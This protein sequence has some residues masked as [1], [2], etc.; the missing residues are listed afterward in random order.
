[1]LLRQ[2]NDVV[3]W[4]FIERAIRFGARRDRAMPP[5][6]AVGMCESRGK[7]LQLAES[8]GR[9]FCRRCSCILA[10]AFALG[11]P[12][13]G[14]DSVFAAEGREKLAVQ[15]SFGHRGTERKTLT[16][17][18]IAG[19]PGVEVTAVPREITIG[20]G[21]VEVVKVEVACDKSA[22]SA[23][24]PHS[25]WK[26]LLENSVSNQV[27]RL[28]HDPAFRPGVPLLTVLTAPDGTAGFTIGL[29]QLKLHKA[30]WLPEHDAFVTLADSQIGF[31]A[32]LASLKG[33]RILDRV[34]RQPESTLAEWTNKWEDIGN[35]VQYDKP[36]ESTWLG[37]KG[38]L[39]GLTARYG[40]VYKFGIDR[41]ANVRPDLGSPHKFRFDL[42][43]RESKWSGQRIVDGLPI[44]STTFKRNGQS[45][46][47]E[48]FAAPLS[49][50]PANRRG[51]VASVLM[52]VMHVSGAGPI[53]LGFRL[54]TENTNCQPELRQISGQNC[55]VDRA[56]GGLWLMIH[57]GQALAIANIRV[58]Q[59]DTNPTIEF[60]C[61][62]ELST[63]QTNTL[64]VKLPS[65]VA[66]TEAAS[67]LA[68]LDYAKARQATIRYWESWLARGARFEVPE[69]HVNDL[70][71]AS[72]WHALALPRY[73]NDTTGAELMDLPYS[74]FAYGQ[75]GADW[76][77]NHAVYVD[78]MIHG[79]RGYFAVAEEELASMFK[80]QQKDDGRI[81]GYADWGVN[82]PAMLY[83]VAQNYL[84]SRDRM[85]FDRQLPQAL[86]TLDWCIARVKKSQEAKDASGLVVEPLNDLSKEPRP[87]A[88]LNAYYVAGLEKFGAALEAHGHPRAEEA[89]SVAELL[90]DCVRREFARAS[91]KAPVVQLEDGSWINL[92]P[93]DAAE[94]RRLVEQ[95]YPTDVDTGP[96]HLARLSVVD[97]RG[98]LA[99]AMLN[100]HEDN[101][102][103]NQWG[104][105]NEP[106]YN[107]QGTV[108]LLRDEPEAA[109]W[110]FYSMM[111]CA[112]SHNQLTPLE[113]RWAWGQYYMPPS[114]DGAWFELYRNMLL[115][116]LRGDG[117]LFI[118]EAV[119]RP[120][121][122]DGKQIVVAGAPTYFGPVNLRISSASATGL[123][124]AS[125]EF[126]SDRRPSAIL[127]RIRHPE[128]KPLQ[129]AMVNDAQWTD[130]D[131]A[132]E[133]IRIQKPTEARYVVI[134]RY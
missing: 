25:I 36:W 126:L 19:S 111:A 10:I 68:A 7:V 58:A 107:Q 86:K 89:K 26:Y 121:L 8:R 67:T 90:R 94:P 95:W 113:H 2:N 54:S 24:Q 93:S 66:A 30:M 5:A 52:T 41:W 78:Y 127:V 20:G 63:G 110:T 105:A 57:P 124:T 101:L 115:N 77:I 44:L 103:L 73:R 112:F 104:M 9:E 85:A 70:C 34:R 22:L 119:P 92:V 84:L 118:G 72:L 28:K 37:T 91:V 130:L 76:P 42:A 18:F 82:S 131:P 69:K 43:W 51:E 75:T 81:S 132:K 108:C 50:P 3:I 96:L 17:R 48:Q 87:W 123:I 12:N 46:E 65:P 16:P 39:T 14:L 61:V 79:L 83:A 31:S 11:W 35:P 102:F 80:S 116:E 88:F 33:E 23:R 60:D 100:D 74:N 106:V 134:A 59:A 45:C 27:E 4:Q 117:T 128:K 99:A 47:I 62:G 98:W 38:H 21:A 71:R 129:S 97:P 13:A 56:T 64:V 32:H 109:I 40:S 6:V 49:E 55:V 120:W 1:M 15:V 29:E 125:I 133:W 122:A 114:T 53:N